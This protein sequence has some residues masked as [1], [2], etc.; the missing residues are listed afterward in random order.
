MDLESNI[1]IFGEEI[2]NYF[3][4]NNDNIEINNDYSTEFCTNCKNNNLVIDTTNAIIVCTKCGQ[5]QGY[6]LDANPEWRQYDDDTKNDVPRCGKVINQLLPQSSLGT[7]VNAYGRIKQIHSWNAMPYKERSLNGVFK[8]IT[9]VCLKYNIPKKIL[10]DAQI[11]YKKVSECT[12]DNGKNKGKSIITRGINRD[13]IIASS[14]FFACRKNNLTRSPKE[15][16]K[17]FNLAETDLNRGGKN[18]QKLKK[19]SLPGS[20]MGTS[21]PIDFIKRKC[22][23]LQIKSDYTEVAKKIAINIEKLNIASTHTSYSLAAASILLMAEH[24]NLRT[25]TKKN[26]S[27]IFEVSDVTITKTFKKILGFKR[28]LF[29]DNY[30]NIILKNIIKNEKKNLISKELYNRMK[31]FGVNTDGY[32]IDNENTKDKFLQL[33]E[34]FLSKLNK[35]DNIDKKKDIM[36]NIENLSNYDSIGTKISKLINN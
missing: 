9:E 23:E 29:N 14:L 12:H 1:D 4:N 11:M 2:E 31:K 28:I 32:V 33:I 35:T 27:K 20:Y 18:F 22:D 13:S 5:T 15:I 3:I 36:D 10:E 26:L 17:M 34:N 8:K 21:T 25:I 24:C 16:A 7:Q 6:I 19:K 30:V